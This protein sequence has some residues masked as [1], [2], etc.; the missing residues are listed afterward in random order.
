MKAYSE[1]GAQKAFGG[2]ALATAAGAVRRRYRWSLYQA[3][4]RDPVWRCD[5]PMCA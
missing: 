2:R 5:G 4:G 3:P 1:A